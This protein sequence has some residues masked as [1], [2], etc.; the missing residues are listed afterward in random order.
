MRNW[1]VQGL[2][3]ILCGLT[4]LLGVM[5]A[6]RAARASLHNRAVY[7][8]PFE[9]ID[10]QPPEGMS[11]AAFLNEVRAL[12]CQPAWLHL[13]DQDLPSRVHRAFLAHPWVE[14]VRLVAIEPREP[15]GPASSR[16][17]SV[18][19][20]A[21]YR[22]AVLAV[23]QSS[24]KSGTQKAVREWRM[25]DRHGILLPETA[26]RSHLPVLSANVATP[27][28]PPGSPWGDARVTVAAR[29]VAFLQSHL[30]R[31]HL[32]DSQIEVIE[33]EIVF[34][35]PGTRI[36]WGHAPGQ[37]NADEA[38]AKIKLKRLLDYQ[39]E[40][41]GLE[42]LE[43]DVRLLAYQGHFPLTPDQAPN[44]VSLSEASQLPSRRTREQLSNSSRSWRSCF[45]DAGLPSA[46][47]PSR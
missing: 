47:G 45:N 36:V 30:A 6:G 12:T 21:E 34:H 17:S 8:L 27:A 3:P 9:D 16:H 26:A 29:T 25:V 24:D 11:R 2:T 5:A 14:S 39:K 43:H 37:E 42:T 33:G 40:H 10:C 13:L 38:P 46:D 41:D 32:E 7:T 15:V 28:G 18:R 20:E 31:L 35:L 1:L 4:L 19:I 44:A 23:S 22:R